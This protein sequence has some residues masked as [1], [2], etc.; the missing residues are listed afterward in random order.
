MMLDFCIVGGGIIGLSTAVALIERFPGR[1]IVLLEKEDKLALHQTGHNSGVIHAGIYYK[2][3]SLKAQL[4]REGAK[5]VRAFCRE[6]GIAFETRGKLVVATRPEEVDRLPALQ[7]NAAE[8]QIG[9]E[10]LDARELRAREPNAAGLAALFVADSGIVDYRLVAESLAAR[11]MAAGGLIET[12]SKVRALRE[13][14]DAV[15]IE[16]DSN[17]W[18]TRRLVACAGL[19]SDRLARL[20]GLDPK[21][22]IVPF[23]GEYYVLP[24]SRSEIVHHMIYPV[25]DP[26]LPF[27]G[28]HLT[29]TIDGDMTVGPNA[30]LGFSREGYR[31]LS[32]TPRDVH[33]IVGYSGLW[34]LAAKHWRSGLAEMANSLSK[35]RYLQECRRYCPSLE[36]TDLLPKEA[37]IRAQFVTDSGELF[38]DFLFLETR[39]MLHVCNAPSPA[40]TSSI[41]IGHHIAE[42]MI[43][44]P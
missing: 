14:A 17:S 11:F 26:D 33:E 41:P 8:N 42:R 2:A 3:G 35:Q 22:R 34:R 44:E 9:T 15:T 12:G 20:A 29:P 21:G 7:R 39:R 40:A 6:Q 38:H 28:I 32:V 36:I 30:V 37:G 25:P 43:G 4:C 31:R 27:L 10:L 5:A 19:Q 13:T 23:R 16:G 18:Q 24:R 1:N